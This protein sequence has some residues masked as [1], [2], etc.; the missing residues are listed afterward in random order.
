MHGRA[1]LLL[2]GATSCAGLSCSGGP[3]SKDRVEFVRQAASGSDQTLSIHDRRRLI[4]DLRS[5]DAAVRMA[6]FEAL[7]RLT[8]MDQGFEPSG[9]ETERAAAIDRWEAW[10]RQEELAG[11]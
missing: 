11:E 9:T 3:E 5:D 7:R 10:E 8:G 1:C 4:A 2:L 6:A